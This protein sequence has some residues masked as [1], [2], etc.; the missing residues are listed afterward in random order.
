MA[1]YSA[2]ALIKTLYSPHGEE[3]RQFVKTVSGGLLG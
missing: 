2:L 3:T 1:E